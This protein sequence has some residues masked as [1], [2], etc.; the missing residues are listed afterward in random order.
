MNIEG[1]K[2][3][4]SN[5]EKL[6]WPEVGIR[7]IDYLARM[8][9]LSPY[10]LPH[11]ENRLLT[12]IRFPD[13][14]HGESFFSKN[15]PDYAPEW[16]KREEWNDTEYAILDS[17]PTLA[18]FVN[19][20][21]LEFHTSFNTYS[22]EDYPTSIVFDLDPSQGQSFD[23]VIE[24]ALLI[25]EVLDSL[26]ITGYIKTS[27]ASGMQLYIPTA[28]KYD[29]TVARKI[30]EFFGSYFAQKYPK[31]ITIERK[32]DKRGRKLYFDYLQMWQ[33]KTI[34]MVYSPRAKEKATVSMP[35][36]WSEIE[37]GINPEDF[38]LNNA[39]E[40]LKKIGDLF[41][42]LLNAKEPEKSLDEVVK[43]ILNSDINN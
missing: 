29:Y 26:S 35:V 24:V 10:L 3:K 38:T 40:R 21:A 23:E 27:G 25:K 43:H 6:L 15:L 30:N 34:T 22:K 19:M 4:L 14:I 1:K 2:V 9:E 18:W 28:G 13:G 32:V 5:P 17:L 16:I 33:G 41:E 11:A 36:T 37:N 7:K 39:L 12:T 8:I 31:K 42:P 20:A